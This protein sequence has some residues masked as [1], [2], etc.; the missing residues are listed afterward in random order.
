MS[1]KELLKQYI[2][3][4]ELLED[5]VR[6]IITREV[7]NDDAAYISV[8]GMNW[9]DST[10]GVPFIDAHNQHGSITENLLGR[11]MNL[12]RTEIDGA[13]VIVGDLVFAETE[14]GKIAKELYKSGIAR[15]VSVGVTYYEEDV[16]RENGYIG[17]SMLYEVSGVIVGANEYAKVLQQA[18]MEKPDLEKLVGNYN[19][20]KPKI[21]EYRQAF[22][23]DELFEKLEIEKTGDE[24]QDIELVLTTIQSKLKPVEVVEAKETPKPV[25]TPPALTKT[26]VQEFFNSINLDI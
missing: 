13:K 7:Q 10:E 11:V 20:I 14:K 26:E 4:T 21:K 6:V 8:D 16:D 3:K 23:S 24:V 17:K 1:K 19:D 22:M 25:E 5:S 9:R 12:Q 2:T 18:K 15:D